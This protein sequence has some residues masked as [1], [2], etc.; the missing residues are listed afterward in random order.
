MKR[1]FL[2]MGLAGVVGALIATL[3]I[4][5]ASA[6][7]TP[8]TT[9]S[10]TVSDFAFT[11]G[12]GSTTVNIA[13]GGTVN[14]SYPTGGNE[15]NVDFGTGPQPTSCTINGADQAPPIPAAPTAPGWSGSCTF[16]TPGT[17]TF[18]CD[19]HSFMTGTI[20]V[21]GDA[22]TT[23]TTTGTQTQP[24]GGG[25]TTDTSTGAS[26]TTTMP[27]NM[28]MPMP[29][30]TTGGSTTTKTGTPAKPTPSPL[31]GSLRNSIKI[32]TIQSGNQV[33]GTL[34]ISAA[35]RGGHVLITVLASR[36]GLKH[37]TAHGKQLV[38][39]ASKRLSGLRPGTAKF[40]LAV[41]GTGRKALTTYRRL[42]T[43]V[44]VKVTAPHSKTVTLAKS[45][46]LRAG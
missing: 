38:T 41:G 11:A 20:V 15:H 43:I 10:F 39:L 26:T 8:P 45:V 44:D 4:L 5:T 3:P 12:D 31:A 23:T 18:H 37:G 24:G 32:A 29:M 19:R 35:G 7:P 16:N 2:L 25:S 30:P 46:V 6:A 28:P 17:Y 40:T 42:A 34:K 21:G 36:S 9:G 22:T 13:T 27:M 1:R 33:R 14:F